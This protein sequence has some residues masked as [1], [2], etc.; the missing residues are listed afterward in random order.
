MIRQAHHERK[1]VQ[2]IVLQLLSKEQLTALHQ[3]A[4]TPDRDIERFSPKFI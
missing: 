4:A 1:F 3:L 2:L